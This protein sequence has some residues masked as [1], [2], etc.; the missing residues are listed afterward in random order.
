[1]LVLFYTESHFENS[2]NP[3]DSTEVC[4]LKSCFSYIFLK[5][6]F[7]CTLDQTQSRQRKKGSRQNSHSFSVLVLVLI[8]LYFCEGSS[9]GLKGLRNCLDR[10]CTVQTRSRHSPDSVKIRFRQNSDMLQVLTILNVKKDS[11]Q[12]L[13]TVQ[14]E[15]G[16]SQDRIYTQPIQS[17]DKVQTEFRQAL[18]LSNPERV[19]I[20]TVQTGSRQSR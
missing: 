7:I 3:V 17:Q 1:M 6:P 11:R 13:D 5:A 15:S 8:S 19:K 18:G 9:F 4:I 12:S 14:T 20:H 16:Q 2:G 10:A